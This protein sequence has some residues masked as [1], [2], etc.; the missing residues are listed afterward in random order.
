MLLASAIRKPYML[1]PTGQHA[2]KY[3]EMIT[4]AS[5]N[6]NIIGI[7][8]DCDI[9]M[10]RGV[11]QGHETGRGYLRI[12]GLREKVL[13]DMLVGVRDF[14][15]TLTSS[16]IITFLCN[17]YFNCPALLTPDQIGNLLFASKVQTIIRK[18]L[19]IYTIRR[20]IY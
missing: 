18:K 3:V 6:I 1:I 19:P 11:M 4:T 20:V 9:I 17:R 12:V 14:E 5:Y 8:S 16:G 15:C 7:F 10:R 13:R 2:P